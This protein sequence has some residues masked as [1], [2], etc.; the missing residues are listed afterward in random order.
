MKQIGILIKQGKVDSFDTATSRGVLI[1]G[2]ERVLFHSTCFHSAP[3]TRF[4]RQG[5]LILAVFSNGRLVSVRSDAATAG[6]KQ[7]A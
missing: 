4:P 2:E 7:A 3:P 1:L 5:E 6:A